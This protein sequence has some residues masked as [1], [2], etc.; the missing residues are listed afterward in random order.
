MDRTDL[1]NMSGMT[2]Y[3]ALKFMSVAFPELIPV[4]DLLASWSLRV[5]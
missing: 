1:K 3:K 2:T 4:S 5:E